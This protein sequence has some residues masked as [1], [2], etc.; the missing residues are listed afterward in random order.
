MLPR[1]WEIFFLIC[2]GQ[3]SQVIE[4]SSDVHDR[5]SRQVQENSLKFSSSM[6]TTPSAY[7]SL[8]LSVRN[9]GYSSLT[10]LEEP[11]SLSNSGFRYVAEPPYCRCLSDL[12]YCDFFSFFNSLFSSLTA[13]K[14][15][16]STPRKTNIVVSRND[17]KK[18]ECAT[19]HSNPIITACDSP[20]TKLLCLFQLRALCLSSYFLNPDELCRS[21]LIVIKFF[22]FLC[23]H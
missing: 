4:S 12:K 3:R 18:R 15:S 1:E 21:F 23:S 5:R 2:S 17:G 11:I 14:P 9:T 22:L 6:K 8:I 13:F 10:A 19:R 7:Y 16:W 20:S